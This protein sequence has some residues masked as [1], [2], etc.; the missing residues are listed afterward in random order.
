[1]NAT[2]IIPYLVGFGEALA[3]RAPASRTTRVIA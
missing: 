3:T 2:M 1:V